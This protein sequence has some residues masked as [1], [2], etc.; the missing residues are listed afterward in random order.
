MVGDPHLIVTRIA[1]KPGEA[2]LL[3]GLSVECVFSVVLCLSLASS[4]VPLVAVTHS[5]KMHAYPHRV[6]PTASY[7]LPSEG[8][9]QISFF[10][11]AVMIFDVRLLTV[12]VLPSTFYAASPIMLVCEQ[13]VRL[14]ARLLV[15]EGRLI[16]FD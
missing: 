3:I 1:S 16:F 4:S 12:R 15:C 14:T 2:V 7:V 5:P 9:L 6:Q 11:T 10:S 13:Q 8:V